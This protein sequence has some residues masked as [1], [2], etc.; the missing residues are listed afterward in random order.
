MVR[1]APVNQKK[2]KKQKKR[3]W[4]NAYLRWE[5]TCPSSSRRRVARRCNARRFLKRQ[6]SQDHDDD[7]EYKQNFGSKNCP[8]N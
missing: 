4:T 1:K 7:I 6:A 3:K 5:Q 8:S 2:K